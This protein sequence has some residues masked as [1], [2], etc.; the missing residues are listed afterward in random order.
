MLVYVFAIKVQNNFLLFVSAL[1][2]YFYAVISHVKLG[3]H[4]SPNTLV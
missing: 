4:K 2:T 1:P 3:P